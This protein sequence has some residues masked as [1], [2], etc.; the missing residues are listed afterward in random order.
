MNLH[1]I[2]ARIAAITAVAILLTVVVIFAAC[3]STV[4][5]ENDRRSLEMMNLIASDTGKSL[6]EY[7][8]SIEQSVEAAANLAEDSLDSVL[9]IE[10]GAAGDYVKP[11]DRTDA[12]N[13]A[14]D[15]H[16]S[17]HCRLLRETFGSIANRSYGVVTYY[18][19]I[20]PEVSSNVHGF[21]Y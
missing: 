14:I 18:Y 3:Y 9:L 20:N 1:S 11:E 12:Q 21:F 6:E 10:N 8:E 5:K 19:C 16:L 2:R 13:A 7:L 15:K 17:E 4:K